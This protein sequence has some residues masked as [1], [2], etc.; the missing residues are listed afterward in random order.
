MTNLVSKIKGFTLVEL[1]LVVALFLTVFGG[2]AISLSSFLNRSD[3]DQTTKEVVQM[4]RQAQG[5]SMAHYQ[6]SS[7][8]VYLEDTA[9]RL[10][11]FQGS[12]YAARVPSFDRVTELSTSLDL[13]SISL[14][15]G[16]NEIVF[17]KGKGETTGVGSF[18]IQ[19]ISSG[20]QKTLT[21]NA[22]GQIEIN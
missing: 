14:I 1:I 19:E 15:G 16:G 20:N 9:N 6:D 2:T 10:T 17:T 22:Y 3:L 12:S 11:F 18:V 8:G 21:L 4:L 7:W 13:M 5:Y